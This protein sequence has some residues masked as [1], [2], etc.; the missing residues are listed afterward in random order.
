[1]RFAVIDNGMVENIIVAD[2]AQKDELAQALGMELIDA[3]PL[4]L[5]IGDMLTPRGWTRNVDGE[6]VVL[7]IATANPDVEEILAILEGRIP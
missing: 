5:Q 7:P 1:M 6:Q 3:A 2:E 4:G